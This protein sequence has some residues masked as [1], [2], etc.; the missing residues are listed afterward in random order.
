MSSALV[1]PVLRTHLKAARAGSVAIVT[2]KELAE[3]NTNYAQGGIAAVLDESDSFSLHRDD[4]HKGG[5]WS[6]P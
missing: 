3:S 5:T 4:T 2:K 6:L 1:S